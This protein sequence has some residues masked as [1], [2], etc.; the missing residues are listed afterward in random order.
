[1]DYHSSK[2]RKALV[3]NIGNNP[4]EISPFNTTLAIHKYADNPKIQQ[5]IT[6]RRVDFRVSSLSSRG[7]VRHSSMNW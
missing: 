5:S 6:N 7:K 2:A 3:Q 1:M 4:M